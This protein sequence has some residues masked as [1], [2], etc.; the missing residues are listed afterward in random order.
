MGVYAHEYVSVHTHALTAF[1]SESRVHMVVCERG[2]ECVECAQVSESMC[3]CV[4][5]H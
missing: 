3:M 5:M 2:W 1:E 4:N